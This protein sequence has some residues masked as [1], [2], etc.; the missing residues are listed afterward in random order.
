M[1]VALQPTGGLISERIKLTN[2]SATEIL[3]LGRPVLVFG[4]EAVNT[5]DADLVITLQ[6]AD[7]TTTWLKRDVELHP[8][9]CLAV[10]TAFSLAQGESLQAISSSATGDLDIEVTYQIPDATGRR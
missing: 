2:C 1:S 9:D 3:A 10:E 6:V 4:V 7:G 8:G 5:S